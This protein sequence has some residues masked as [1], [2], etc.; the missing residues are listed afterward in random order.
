MQ[1]GEVFADLRRDKGLKQCEM[2]EIL[3]ISP[4]VISSYERN[5]RE[6]S[7]EM[8]IEIAKF[9]NVS[10]D[11]LLG[12]T[13]LPFAPSLLEKEFVDGVTYSS[14]L[15]ILPRLNPEQRS[16]LLTVLDNMKFY[17]E[18][19]EQ[20]KYFSEASQKTVHKGVCKK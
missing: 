2:G 17:A 1:F 20:T 18:I 13:D 9:F 14:I 15:N 19:A 11:Y 7:F 12:L 3:H 16:A 10:V 6:P 5:K 8:L 4:Q